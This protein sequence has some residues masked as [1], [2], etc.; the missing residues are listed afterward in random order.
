MLCVYCRPDTLLVPPLQPVLVQGL[1][2]QHKCFLTQ[3]VCRGA[4]GAKHTFC[5]CLAQFGHKKHQ[6]HKENYTHLSRA[7]LE[8]RKCT[9]A[10]HHTS[11]SPLPVVCVISHALPSISHVTTFHPFSYHSSQLFSI[12]HKLQ[13]PDPVQGQGPGLLHYVISY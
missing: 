9:C 5:V 1:F 11:T 12:A 13:T 10:T 7:M 8:Y 3:R 6:I 2:L 4:V